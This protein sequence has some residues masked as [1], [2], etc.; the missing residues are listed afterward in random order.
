MIEAWAKAFAQL[1]DARLRRPVLLGTAAGALLFA[2][3]LALG[4]WLVA[5]ALA[6][7]FWF[8]RALAALG[9]LAAVLVALVLFQPASLAIA[10]LLLDGVADAVEARHYPNLPPASPAPLGAQI[11]A[12]LRLAGRV[13]ILSLLALPFA[14]LLPGVGGLVWLAVSA[15]ALSREYFELAALRRMEAEEARTLR[16]A[17][18]LRVWLAGVPAAA[19]TLVPVVNLR[20]P[21]LGAAAFVHVFHRTAK[22]PR[23]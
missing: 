4:G 14:L 9:G 22:P 18:R 7:G 16:R 13:A 23:G 19:L 12:S 1:G 20:V 15:Y 6:G 3:L 2:G 5:L 10:G 11:R 8:E 21:A 17:N